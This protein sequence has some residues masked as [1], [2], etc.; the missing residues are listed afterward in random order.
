MTAE[1]FVGNEASCRVLEKNGYRREPGAQARPISDDA[2][3][4]D[5]EQWVFTLTRSDFDE[6]HHGREPLEED[7]SIAS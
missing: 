1:V 7:V 3:R 4:S 6:N 2:L 5:R